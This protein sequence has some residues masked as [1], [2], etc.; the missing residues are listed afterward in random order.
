M[1]RSIRI[2]YAGA[3]YHVMARGNRR[4]RIFRDETDRKFFCQTLGEACGR[5]GWRVHAW[6]LLSNHYHLMVETPEPN[7]VEGMKWLQ[8]TYTRRFNSRHRLWGRLF[9]DRYKAILSEGRS[10]YYYNS[11]MDYIHLNPVRA[12]LVR[13]EDGQS[14]RDYPWSSLA[15]G[16]AVPARKRLPWLAANEGLAMAQCADTAAGRRRF[17]EHLDERARA[18][19]A[20]RAGIIPPADDRRR[21]HL[22]H[23][24]YWGSQAFAERMLELAEKRIVS[25]RNRTY[26]S[27]AI[28]RAHDRAE[29]ERLLREGLVAA[30]LEET[31]LA[32]M[33]GSDAR[34]RA[35]ANLLLERTLVRQSWVAER[36]AMGSAAN[37]SQQVRRYRIKKPKLPPK[38][39]A[40]LRSVKIC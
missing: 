33:P 26:R 24:W 22:R 32:S 27:G 4:E 10:D 28:A 31:V 17:V 8:N 23:G 40:Y 34:K 35:L 13:I 19:G 2:E 9:G 3:F 18:E 16:Y 36:L 11:L 25:R 7:L 6:V 12:G 37:V 38:L 30:A 39:R 14:V 5:T 20:R 29:A 1:A 21:S 15:A